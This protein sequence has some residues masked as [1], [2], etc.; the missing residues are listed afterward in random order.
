MSQALN[1]PTSSIHRDYGATSSATPEVSF[2]AGASSSGNSTNFSPTEFMSLSE[3]IGHNITAIHSSSKQ[4]EKQLK[5]IGTSKDLS[6]LRDKIHGIN[7]KTN[8]R[9]LST[10]QD[11]NVLQS[12]VRHGDR[13]QKLQLDKLTHEFQNVV[14][15][16]STL[17]KKVSQAT[18]QSYQVAAEAERERDS[19]ARTEMLLQQRQEMA[20]LEQQHGMLVDRQ[21]QVEQIEADII[22]VHA[23]M[24]KLNT[25]VVEQRPMLGEYFSPKYN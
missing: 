3:N 14:E 12:V 4:L 7:T 9:V 1:N 15:Q 10:S 5:L 18:R 24:N 6:G 8:A 22:D 17:Q 23:I 2:A 20:G 21:R 13:Q 11:L 19:D 25:L 16:Y